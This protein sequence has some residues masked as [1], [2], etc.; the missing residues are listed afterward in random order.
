MP[1]KKHD[2]TPPYDVKSSLLL[3]NHSSH[4]SAPHLKVVFLFV[5]PT[6]ELVV[7]IFA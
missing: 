2:D 6:L 4:S 1:T 3:S 5:P 7:F